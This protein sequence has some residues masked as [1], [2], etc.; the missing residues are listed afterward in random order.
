MAGFASRS[1]SHYNL[2][3]KA[4]DVSCVRLEIDYLLG[5]SSVTTRTH[6]ETKRHIQVG[7][8]NSRIGFR[9]SRIDRSAG[10]SVSG[11]HGNH[12]RTGRSF[13]PHTS[14]GYLAVGGCLLV[15]AWCTAPNAHRISRDHST[16]ARDRRSLWTQG[17]CLTTAPE[18]N[19]IASL[20]EA[21]DVRCVRLEIDLLGDF[22]LFE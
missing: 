20:P 13:C 6:N 4:G 22:A 10:D 17:R 16:L 9:V 21:G 8:P 19:F 5:T 7:S 14:H 3:P 15:V 18:L 1:D 12:G 2:L 11:P